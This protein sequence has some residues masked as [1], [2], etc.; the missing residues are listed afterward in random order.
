MVFPGAWWSYSGN[1]QRPITL[2]GASSSLPGVELHHSFRCCHWSATAEVLLVSSALITHKHGI[3][4]MSRLSL[5]FHP[6]HWGTS[7]SP[8]VSCI[9]TIVSDSSTC[10]VGLLGLTQPWMAIDRS[11]RHHRGSRG[12][13]IH[14][15]VQYFHTTKN[16]QHRLRR[17]LK[18]ASTSHLDSEHP[19]ACVLFP[20]GLKTDF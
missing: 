8:C 9:T 18:T 10:R 13:A 11:T 6:L 20:I 3:F 2:S 1:L 12:A 7:R 19:A 15:S 4:M 5:P 17:A 14:S 16:V